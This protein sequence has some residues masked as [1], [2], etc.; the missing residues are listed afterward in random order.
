VF[1]DWLAENKEDYFSVLGFY[2][3]AAAHAWDE[4][5]NHHVGY[6]FT[7]PDL[8][9]DAVYALGATHLKHGRLKE[10]RQMLETMLRWPRGDLAAPTAFLLARCYEALGETKKARQ[11]YQD[12]IDSFSQCGLLDD[13]ES[14]MAR[15]DRGVV[16]KDQV[17]YEDEGLLYDIY[18]GKNILVLA[19]PL[20]SPLM[21][22]YNLPN[23][24]D[25]AHGSLKQWTGLN[26]NGQQVI[27]L[28]ETLQG[29]QPGY[30]IRIAA[31]AISDPPNWRLGLRELAYNFVTCPTYQVIPTVSPAAGEAFAQFAAATLQYNLV[32][33]TR[34]TIGSASATKLAHEDVI[35]QREEALAALREYVDGGASLENLNGLAVTGMLVELLDRHG[36]GENGLLDWSPYR[37][38]FQAL[39]QLPPELRSNTDSIQ[40]SHVL[41]HCLNRAF[42]D[43]LT[44]T[45]QGWG[46]P[47]TAEGVQQVARGKLPGSG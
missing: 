36:Y 1:P 5:H 3:R 34:D 17:L 30:P 8:Y 19:P 4:D 9:D 21:R 7:I 40:G 10:A 18:F 23:I 29:G 16:G 31:A 32:S 41:V 47:V 45:F 39:L 15:L 6:Q 27:L 24:W 43:D 33:E 46:F 11:C 28:D 25:E 38:F 22:E 44:A 13:A 26:T 14:A 35:R 12:V 2:A 42:N 20:R 37:K